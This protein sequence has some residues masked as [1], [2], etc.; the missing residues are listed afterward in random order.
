MLLNCVGGLNALVGEFLIW[1]LILG[2]LFLVF[3]R[4]DCTSV[5]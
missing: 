5:G 1:V 3:G 4:R 2:Y